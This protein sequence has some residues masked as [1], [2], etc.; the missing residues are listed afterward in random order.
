MTLGSD[1][2]PYWDATI[3]GEYEVAR[4]HWGLDDAELTEIT[5][6]AVEAAF[7]PDDLRSALLARIQQ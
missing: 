6:T 7:V 1:D 4:A 2:P 5:L 3:G